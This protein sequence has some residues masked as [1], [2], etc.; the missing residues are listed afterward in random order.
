M[1]EAIGESKYIS[2]D[3]KR[4]SLEVGVGVLR[5]RAGEAK[6]ISEAHVS[7]MPESEG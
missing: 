1:S 4:L 6:E 5:G 3:D 2:I 7:E